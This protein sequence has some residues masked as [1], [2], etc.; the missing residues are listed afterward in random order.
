[1]VGGM[2]AALLAFGLHPAQAAP[3]DP[4]AV[5]VEET[6]PDPEESFERADPV[7]AQVTA[8]STGERVEDT[9][10]RT[11]S[12]RVFANPDGSWSLESYTAPIF[13]KNAAGEFVEVGS[14]R[15]LESDGLTMVGPAASLEVAD[16]QQNAGEGPT[17]ES[18]ALAT[19]TAE[20]AE[21]EPTGSMT[22][23]WEAELPAPVVEENQAVFSDGVT[24]PAVSPSE[25][26][27]DVA[28][29]SPSS[30]PAASE[31]AA[32]ESSAA[33]D[34]E[35]SAASSVDPSDAAIDPEGEQESAESPEADASAAPGSAT[36]ESAPGVVSEV[37]GTVV[38]DAHAFGFSHS[39]VLESAPASDVVLRFPLGL[40][41]G[42]SADLDEDSGEVRVTDD[43]GELVFLGQAPVMWDAAMDEGSGL[44]A[45]EEPVGARLLDEES[46]PVLELTAPVQWLGA[47]ERQYPVTIDPTWSALASSDTWV[48]S[49]ITTSKAGD[50]ELRVGTFDSGTTKARSLLKFGTSALTGKHIEKAELRLSNHYSYSCT[51]STTKVQRVTSDWDAASVRWTS[52]PSATTTG[53]GSTTKSLG[54]SS[55][56]PAA[57]VY[58]PVTPIVQHW[59]EKP[60]ANYGLRI[61]AGSETTNSSW[62]RYRSADYTGTAST[63]PYLLVT[64]NSYPNAPTSPA[65]GSG[66][67][68]SG[69]DGITYV[70]TLR[71]Q[72]RAVVSDPDKSNMRAQFDLSK[73]GVW[74]WTKANGSWVASGSVSTYTVPE[75][76]VEGGRYYFRAWGHDTKLISESPSPRVYF[77]VDTLAPAMPS[78]KATGYPDGWWQESR[79]SSNVFTFT[80]ASADTRQFEVRANDGQARLIDAVDDGSGSGARQGQWSWNPS[81]SNFVSVTAIDRAGNRSAVR[82]FSFM[83][84]LAA[85]SSPTMGQTSSDVFS[86][87]AQAPK[88]TDDNVTAE[89]FWRDA[90]VK[91]ADTETAYGSSADADGWVK[92]KDVPVT[93]GSSALSVSTS[94][95]VFAEPATGNPLKDAGRTRV[96]ALV[97]VQV[98][99][100]YPGQHVSRR[101]QCSTNQ[102]NAATAVTRL[103]HAFGEN[104]PTAEAGDGQVALTTGEFNT[105]ATDV[106]ADTGTSGLSVSRSYSSYAGSLA[107]TGVFGSGWRVNWDGP[108]EGLAGLAVIDSTGLDGAIAFIDDDQS[109]VMFRQAGGTNTAGKTGA[110]L[111]ADDAA[112][113]TGFKV[114][115][116][117]TGTAARIRAT[118]PDGT[119]TV[120][121]KGAQVPGISGVFE[122]VPEQVTSP[123]GAGAVQFTRNTTTGKI[124]KITAGTEAT[125]NCSTPVRGCRVLN[126]A[127]NTGGQVTKV[128]FTA[129]DPQAAAM[130]T[131]DVAEYAYATSNG[132]TVLA[133][134]KDSRTGDVTRYTY[135]A[136]SAAGVPLISEVREETATGTAV[137]APTKYGYGAGAES[138]RADWLEKVLRGNPAGGTAADVQVGRFVY[139]VDPAG[140]GTALPNL[141]SAAVKV[142]EQQNAPVRGAAVFDQR[143]AVTS[144][145]ASS[146]AAGDFKYADLQ[147]WDERS[148]VSNNAYYAGGGWQFDA[149]VYDGDDQVV[150]SYA[151]PDL[152]ALR[153]D[154]SAAGALN[155][156]GVFGPHEEYATV[157]SYVEAPEGASPEVAE[158]VKTFV[159][160]TLTP[161]TTNEN[162]GSSRMRVVQ[163]YTPFSDV[164][165]AGLPRMLL[166]KEQTE[167]VIYVDAAESGTQTKTLGT[168]TFGYNAL[169]A[170]KD[171]RTTTD[172]ANLRSGWVNGAPTVTTQTVGGSAGN[173]TSRTWLDD[174]GRV[175]KT[176][177]PKSN[178]NDA[179]ATETVYYSQGANTARPECGNRP[180]DQGRVCKTIPLGAGSV[181]EHF[182]GYNIYGEPAT[183]T[184]TPSGSASSPETRTTTITYRPDGQVHTR[185]VS[186]SNTSV[187]SVPTVEYL[188][189]SAGRK[190]G[191]KTGTSQVSWVLDAWGRTTKYTNADNDVTT[192]SYNSIGQVQKVT[193]PHGATEYWY[194]AA[195]GHGS[196]EFRALP[197]K[198]TVTNHGAAGSTGT[199][200]AVYD[201]AGNLTTQTMPG[202]I[203]QVRSYDA[204]GRVTDLAYRGAITSDG[205]T[206]TGDWVSWSLAYRADGKIAAEAS[207]DGLAPE[208]GEAEGVGAYE[209]KYAYDQV[210]RLTSVTDA[211]TDQKRAYTFDANGNRT[212]L[213]TTNGLST[214]SPS[215][216]SK[217]WSWDAADRPTT[218]G[219]TIDTLGRM[220]AIPAVDAPATGT[221]APKGGA[222]GAGITIGYFAND[223]ARTITRD[224]VSSTVTMDASQRRHVINDV[225]GGTRYRYADES[226]NPAWTSNSSGGTT[227]VT[228]FGDVIGGDLGLVI[229]DGKVRLSLNNPHGDTVATVT[230]PGSG[231]AQ[232]IDSWSSFDEYGNPAGPLAAT[233]AGTRY[234]WHGADQRAANATT[235]LIL[236]GARLYN[237]ATGL[238][239]TRDPVAGGNTTTYAYPQDPINKEDV[240]GEWSKWKKSW[241]TAKKWT[242][243][244]WGKLGGKYGVLKK[245]S[246]I[247][248]FFGPIG[249]GISLATGA[250]VAY[251]DYKRGNK[252]AW[253]NYAVSA[254]ATVT[255][256]GKGMA[257]ARAIRSVGGKAA[258]RSGNRYKRYNNYA[259]GLVGAGQN[260]GCRAGN[261]YRKK[262]RR[263]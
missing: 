79:P 56:C 157:M 248:G 105:A 142:W 33:D 44:P 42:L 240:S 108:D 1:M 185:A 20:D 138:G 111:A 23:G 158:H 143:K 109:A 171:G 99:F 148:R 262:S 224:G 178:G 181:I 186:S 201:A 29:A 118:E 234:G 195:T 123:G 75:N 256:V 84:G 31:S 189:D 92:A 260:Y 93:T 36:A 95:D 59:A 215:S 183:L 37:P 114:E 249:V 90:T 6:A 73:G 45:H 62:K 213:S 35:S 131:I 130:A 58:V 80:S 228:R 50:P 210:D 167:E 27:E 162:G 160:E 97:E 65:F 3:E 218:S 128:T 125:L 137:V 15:T 135:G 242:K 48:Q 173:I 53:E 233:G 188:Y 122:W 169:E 199:Y 83:N 221:T 192:T 225:N 200:T 119:V 11:A 216:S 14:G 86:V 243:R 153:A 127:Y 34:T 156:D 236:M 49:G 174:Q 190:N 82:K 144:S 168:K 124:T 5:E 176:A 112:E 40:S 104:F 244:G 10:Q 241:Q 7:S 237:P 257:M 117:G 69:A 30:A 28:E 13:E 165:A 223:T 4:V 230:L 209:R 133:S 16:G 251:L 19:L 32:A 41:K 239:T 211:V 139:G 132:K 136:L 116:T 25:E 191:E 252:K 146:V 21:G 39:V 187:T 26:G 151:A 208:L 180:E 145:K 219:Y 204:A 261:W 106:K 46:G 198:M 205:V 129:W 140:S 74:E 253:R 255:F 246:T 66:Q 134:V 12:E 91:D 107:S 115:I 227:T 214:A 120:F 18:V 263:C 150:R 57:S 232:G 182:A 70:R 113:A 76:L 194:G 250:G 238:F 110:Y 259:S 220:T 170:D 64:Y 231:N 126:I 235:G 222:G 52:Q 217:S 202:G 55:S 166:L 141:S 81:G 43:D 207:P 9:S 8:R 47:D 71:P 226:D 17:N 60:S 254:V 100:T 164:D 197:T 193:T 161:V 85:L 54:Y 212:G 121:G 72:L 149:T 203:S 24:V 96:P 89:V 87:Q 51:S 245:I 152:G 179:G 22:L 38:V 103:P 184:E 154:A 102:A 247:S 2:V 78:V 94:L 172:K 77:T 88:S 175:K 163:E 206:E 147:F 101:V 61:I 63:R 229:E 98:C 177:Q 67:A 68:F 258:A 159:A 196:S 155:A